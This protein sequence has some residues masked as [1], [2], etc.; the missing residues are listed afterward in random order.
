MVLNC[1]GCGLKRTGGAAFL[2][3]ESNSERSSL[4]PCERKA[5]RIR[6]EEEEKLTNEIGLEESIRIDHTKDLKKEWIDRKIDVSE[7]VHTCAHLYSWCVC[8]HVG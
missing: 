6:T 8:L 4:W 7:L 1:C 3:W 5:I 2:F